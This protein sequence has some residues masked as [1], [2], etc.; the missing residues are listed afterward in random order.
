MDDARSPGLSGLANKNLY[1][2]ND[3]E[4]IAYSLA[5][6]GPAKSAN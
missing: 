4:I 5:A 3:E 6:S 1:I 2:R